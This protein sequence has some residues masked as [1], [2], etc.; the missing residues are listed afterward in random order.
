MRFLRLMN[1]R[2][3]SLLRKSS[4]L[5]FIMGVPPLTGDR[6]RHCHTHAIQLLNGYLKM[7]NSLEATSVKPTEN[8]AAP[9]ETI[10]NQFEDFGKSVFH[11]GVEDPYNGV[12]QLIDHAANA[13]LPELDIVGAPTNDSFGTEAG[14]IVGTAADVVALSMAVG[15]VAP[16]LGAATIAGAVIR[17]AIIGAAYGGLFQPSDSSSTNFVEDRVKNGLVDAAA[18]ATMGGV[19]GGLAKTGLFAV[20]AGR[21]LVGTTEVGALSGGAGGVADAGAN[22]VLNQGRVL[23]TGKELL[24]DT[25]QFAALGAAAGIIGFGANQAIEAARGGPNVVDSQGAKVSVS[26]DA[27]GNPVSF[28]ATLP[29]LGYTDLDDSQL[30]GNGNI[31]GRLMPNGTWSTSA[32]FGVKPLPVDAVSDV[33]ELPDGSVK[34]MDSKGLVRSFTPDGPYEKYSPFK[35]GYR[36]GDPTMTKPASDILGDE[37][38]PGKEVVGA[39]GK[40]AYDGSNNLT[41]MY[42]NK[43]D[44]NSNAQISYNPDGSIKNARLA[45]AT[46]TISLTSTGP[47]SWQAA[48]GKDVYSWNGSVNVNG[49]NSDSPSIQ[50]KPED[51][52]AASFSLSSG[53]A[54][55]ANTLSSTGKYQSI[56]EGYGYVR[57][58]NQGNVFVKGAK[59]ESASINGVQVGNSEAQIKPGDSGKFT[60]SSGDDFAP[61]NDTYNITMG[62]AADGNVTVNG[63]ELTPGGKQVSLYNLVDGAS[64]V[65]ST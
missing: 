11:S 49:A 57:A 40:F 4:E 46:Q 36:A 1:W 59:M 28:K 22:A 53:G 63:Q 39:T 50:I 56:A 62:K 26:H 32:R 19:S 54:D 15:V 64:P 25:T 47:D 45:D 12:V 18:F 41:S 65:P 5:Q 13:H 38:V 31:T 14:K 9:S 23:P 44:A 37:N 24:D 8:N 2:F 30:L 42:S 7:T 60:I 43:G 34:L 27:Q 3:L 10:A 55:V 51:G 17:G 61:A 48:V 35:D 58:D 16:S 29:V 21:S 33:K 6:D 52:K 20:S